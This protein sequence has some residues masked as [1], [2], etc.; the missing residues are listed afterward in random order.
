MIGNLFSIEISW[1]RKFFFPVIGNQ[2]PA[3]TVASFATTIHCLPLTYPIFT[4]TPPL[5]QPPCSV[6]I[7]SPANAAIS[8][9]LVFG[10]SKYS[11]RSLAVIFPLAWCFSILLFPPPSFTFT[12]FCLNAALNN[13]L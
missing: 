5:G 11:M 12:S 9:F 13:L 1:A 3:F 8:I 10:S 4:T 7:L 2:A 6:Y